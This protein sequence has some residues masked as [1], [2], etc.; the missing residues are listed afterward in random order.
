M[1]NDAQFDSSDMRDAV[2]VSST[3]MC[4]AV[5]YCA[6]SQTRRVIRE[7]STFQCQIPTPSEAGTSREPLGRLRS[8]SLVCFVPSDLHE[9]VLGQIFVNLLEERVIRVPLRPPPR[10][11][12]PWRI[13]TMFASLVF[14]P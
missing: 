2:H 10:L 3:D 13:Q 5:Q 9:V 14:V 6:S 1:R 11:V 7:S 12:L 8:K 4:S